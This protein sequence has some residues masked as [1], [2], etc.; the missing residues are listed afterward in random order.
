MNTLSN[1]GVALCF[2]DK[3]DEAVVV[4]DLALENNPDDSDILANKNLAKTRLKHETNHPLLET[5]EI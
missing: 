1:K 3:Y 5:G 4:F 2:L